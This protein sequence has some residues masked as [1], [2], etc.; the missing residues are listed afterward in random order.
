MSHLRKITAV[1]FACL[2]AGLGSSAPAFAED[3]LP[4]P[5]AATVEP[6]VT[7]TPEPARDSDSAAPA[8]PTVSLGPTPGPT[9]AETP[10]PTASPTPPA[11]AP[12]VADPAAAGDTYRITTDKLCPGTLDPAATNVAG[13]VTIDLDEVGVNA[14]LAIDTD[15]AASCKD[16]ITGFEIVGTGTNVF[17]IEIGEYAFAQTSGAANTLTRV[18]F[19]DGPTQL[20]IGQGAFAQYSTVGANTLKEVRFPATAPEIVA[21]FD[22][23]FRQETTASEAGNALASVSITA[24]D[25]TCASGSFAQFSSTGD[26][27]LASVTFALTGT[28]LNIGQSAFQQKAG[29]NN[30]LTSVTIPSGIRESQL[31]VTAF[32]QEAGGDNTLASV[33]LPETLVQFDVFEGAFKQIAGGHNALTSLSFPQTMDYL[34]AD[35]SS[36]TQ[37]NTGTADTALTSVTFPTTIGL[38]A[39][40][41]D[42]FSQTSDGGNTTL[43]TITFP[44]STTFGTGLGYQAF[45]QTATKGSTALASVTLPAITPMMVID[46]RAFAQTSTSNTLTRVVFPATMNTLVVYYEAFAQSS[47]SVLSEVVFPFSTPPSNGTYFDAGAVPSSGVD[48]VWF[49]ADKVT[50]SDWPIVDRKLV[51]AAQQKLTAT[52][53]SSAPQGASASQLLSGYRT[54]TLK[55]LDATKTRYVYRDGQSVT[56]PLS[57]QTSSIGPANANGGWTTTLPSAT[58][59]LGRFAGWCTTAVTG[60]AACTSTILRSG[61]AYTVASNTQLWASWRAAA[62]VPPTIPAQSLGTGTVGKAFRQV[63]TVEGGGDITCA[64]TAGALPAGLSLHGCVLSGTPTVAGT[65]AFTVTATN[66]AGSAERHFTLSVTSSPGQLAHTGADGWGPLLTAAGLLV[67]VGAVLRRQSRT[68]QR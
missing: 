42:A 9:A 46:E 35:I 38:L 48:W 10:Q 27:S 57:G 44:T 20:F 51:A 63:I 8:A 4:T 21:V 47:T 33:S 5:A 68:A 30:A 60:A 22:D 45:A 16:S 56:T 52:P 7:T 55:N 49:G 24:G 31:G 26:N 2:L 15:A 40:G 58:S 64:V 43:R 11:A 65:S 13:A 3:S 14:W 25:L 6:A 50:I 61:S 19:P 23:A 59:T 41:L 1:V 28:V 62:V 29:G 34:N 17:G 53:F 54:L 18:S 36:F 37:R 12:V 32:A 66:S 39:V 67:L